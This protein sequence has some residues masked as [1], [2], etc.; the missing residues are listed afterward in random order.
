MGPHVV[1]HV[2][3]PVV[4]GPNE[5]GFN[6]L[7]LHQHPFACGPLGANTKLTAPLADRSHF[8]AQSDA[9]ATP[10]W[11]D[12]V[13]VPLAHPEHADSLTNACDS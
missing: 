11:N 5:V 9:L 3:G 2:V 1:G 12:S 13:I 7:N 4:V 10:A 8:R 6:V